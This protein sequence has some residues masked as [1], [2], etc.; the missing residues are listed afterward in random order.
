MKYLVVFFLLC[1][2]ALAQ[3]SPPPQ[4]KGHIW[5]DPAWYFSLGASGGDMGVSYSVIDG[6]H[7]REKNPLFRTSDG[8][9][10]LGRAIPVTAGLLAL[11]YKLYENPRH[12]TS[13]RI[14]MYITGAL[15][16]YAVIKGLQLNSRH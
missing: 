3:N 12:R 14:V 5:K 4:D 8:R 15:H 7:I 2:T 16:L 11:E 6:V 10:S 9:F 13:A 1:S